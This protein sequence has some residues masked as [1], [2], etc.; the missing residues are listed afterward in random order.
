MGGTRTAVPVD[1]CRDTVSRTVA[2]LAVDPELARALA[3][4][5]HRTVSNPVAWDQAV[6]IERA[7]Q[8]WSL[9]RPRK[10]S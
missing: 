1:T 9:S 4:T 10:E 6:E 2:H 7:R 5:L 3:A 8:L